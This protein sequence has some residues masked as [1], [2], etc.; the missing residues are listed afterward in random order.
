MITY[1][2]RRLLVPLAALCLAVAGAA[3][4]PAQSLFAPVVRV[5]DSLITEWE[6]DQRARFLELFRTPG[7]LRQIA[8]DRLIEER[9]QRQAAAAA[10]IVPSEEAVAAGM[11]E[12]AARVELTTEEFLLAIGQ[13]GVS[14]EAFR[15]F[16]IAGI[17]WRDLVRRRFADAVRPTP[18][19]IDQRLIETGAAG[20][21][22]LLLTEILLPAE[23]P[24]TA[25]ASRARAGE[26]A[27]LADAGAFAE[28]ARRFSRAPSR[29]RGGELDWLALDQLPEAVRP[30]VANLRPGQTSRPV[31]LGASIGVFHLRDRE[32]IAATP[33]GAL[34]INYATVAAGSPE[35]AAAL[36]ARADRCD[37]LYGLAPAGAVTRDVVPEPQL[38]TAFRA[39]L[40][41]LDPGESVVLPEG[42]GTL[43]MLCARTLDTEAALNRGAVAEELA[44]AGLARRADRL[45]AELRAAATITRF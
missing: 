38:P 32:A 39:R 17:V 9:L 24:A 44:L 43:L 33:P 8:V 11:A 41:T 6:V 22:R 18:E 13:A 36:A 28:A 19:A 7:D 2:T 34:R 20:G 10:G 5:N 29:T 31:D 26:L 35:A 4:A 12:F 42:S 14:A 45:L 21:T 16:V 30:A 23:D 3:P 15:D 27:R 40:A 37:D 25:A 1:L